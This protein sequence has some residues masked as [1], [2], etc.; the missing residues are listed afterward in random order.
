MGLSPFEAPATFSM[1]PFTELAHGVW[2]PKGGMYRVVETLMKFAT[3]AGVEFMLN[4]PVEHVDVIGT[5]IRGVTLSDGRHLDAD[6]IVANT[7][8][9]YVYQ[10]LLPADNFAER[11]SHKRFSCSVISFF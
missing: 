9:P 7:D 11:L 5:A 6:A 3:E 1:M 10:H 8:L 2:Y 4:T